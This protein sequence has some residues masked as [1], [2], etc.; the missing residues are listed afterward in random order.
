[1]TSHTGSAKYVPFE[2]F[3]GRQTDVNVPKTGLKPEKND[4]ENHEWSITIQCQIFVVDR[5]CHATDSPIPMNR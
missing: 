4:T 5:L 3:D 2:C 1:V